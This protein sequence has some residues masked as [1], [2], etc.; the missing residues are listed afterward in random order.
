MILKY[1][2]IGVGTLC[3]GLAILGIFLPLLPTTPFL[4]LAA[5]CYAKSSEK[6]YNWLISH[7][8]F[9][10]YIKQYREGQGIPFRA[11]VLGIT[12]NWTMVLISTIFVAKILLLK[13]FLILSAVGVTIF[14]LRMPT[15]R[16]PIP[17]V[18]AA[19]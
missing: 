12:M 13:V 8:W 7:K 19:S 11:K 15:L 6:F 4:L 3:V 2:L 1:I 18:S 5:A 16:K 17:E 14:M 9:G 10:N